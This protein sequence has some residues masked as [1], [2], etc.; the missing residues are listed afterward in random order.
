MII[1]SKEW[2]LI[3]Q[4]VRMNKGKLVNIDL[5]KGRFVKMYE[6]DA[7]AQGLIKPT[8]SLKPPAAAKLRTP[9]ANKMRKPVTDGL[10]QSA[11][12]ANKAGQQIEVDPVAATD[13]RIA[14]EEIAKLEDDGDPVAAPPPPVEQ[15]GPESIPGIGKASARALAAHGVI[16]LD[17]LKAAQ[18][19]DYLPPKVLA[20]IAEWRLVACDQTERG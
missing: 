10:R 15:P 13:Q 9:P 17:Q 16:T 12:P 7:I 11:S 14:I 20:A 3:N 19:L 5:G 4:E 2:Q 6:A 18:D 1:D 8:G